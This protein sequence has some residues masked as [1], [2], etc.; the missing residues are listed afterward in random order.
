[1]HIAT[2][3]DRRLAPPAK[4]P[5]L[6][7]LRRPE[8][9][10]LPNGIE[11]SC[12]LS[13]DQSITELEL[14]FPATTT[15][16]ASRQRQGY[17]F[18]MLGEGTREK[19]AKQLADAISFLGA[20]LEFSHN[21]DFDLIHISCLSRF[22]GPMLDILEEIW[23]SPAFPE[24][25]WKTLQETQIRQN[26]IQLQKTSFLASRLLKQKLYT[27]QLDYGYSP[28]PD[29]ISGI[30]RDEFPELFGK[31]KNQGPALAI[32]AGNSVAGF[33]ASLPA[34]GCIGKKPLVCRT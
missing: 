30:S 24:K 29:L 6:P 32:L 31:I 4:R 23:S 12:F 26:E 1:M 34:T 25:E 22:F 7:K 16:A 8:T 14:I 15:S 21:P 9:E 11:L 18:R 19:T 10:I 33:L 27:S 20:S 5:S 3:L 28:D 17:L 2:M 13:E